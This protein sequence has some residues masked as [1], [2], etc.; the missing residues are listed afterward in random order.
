MCLKISNIWDRNRFGLKSFNNGGK[1]I[2][3]NILKYYQI[4]KTSVIG[5]KSGCILHQKSH[6]RGTLNKH[7]AVGPWQVCLSIF[8]LHL[9]SGR[10]I[11]WG[12]TCWLEW[13]SPAK[14]VS[15]WWSPIERMT[16]VD[17]AQAQIE[18]ILSLLS[19]KAIRACWL[20]MYWMYLLIYNENDSKSCW[21]VCKYLF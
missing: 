9:K 16:S 11:S 21:K 6:P 18:E 8:G 3:I 7:R 19:N 12:K 10:I 4:T 15:V 2:N 1:G 14:E 5:E 20:G 13:N 17:R